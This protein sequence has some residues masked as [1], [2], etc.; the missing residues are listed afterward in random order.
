MVI[1][2]RLYQTFPESLMAPTDSWSSA[3]VAFADII[4]LFFTDMLRKRAG[5]PESWMQSRFDNI[6]ARAGGRALPPSGWALAPSGRAPPPP[7]EDDRPTEIWED[8]C[9]AVKEGLLI[10]SDRMNLK[11]E[12]LPPRLASFLP[13]SQMDTPL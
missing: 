13:D 8:F 9:G 11:K 4:R 6:M 3:M 10:L 12:D 1:A 2:K 5:S 7:E